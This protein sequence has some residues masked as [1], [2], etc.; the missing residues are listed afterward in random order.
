MQNV[1]GEEGQTECTIGDPKIENGQFIGL[2]N[3][4]TVALFSKIIP[5][6]GCHEGNFHTTSYNWIAFAL[7]QK[8]NRIGLLF[9]YN[10]IRTVILA[11]F[12]Q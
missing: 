3:V 12:L 5:F 6:Q 4:F 8:P 1:G 7:A 9:A 11:Q 2:L 10:Y